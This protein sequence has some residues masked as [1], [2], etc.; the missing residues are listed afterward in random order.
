MAWSK[1]DSSWGTLSAGSLGFRNLAQ[2]ISGTRPNFASSVSTSMR[3]VCDARHDCPSSRFCSPFTKSASHVIRLA[4]GS[5]LY[6]LFEI[7]G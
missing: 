4:L 6:R 5:A 7:G 1:P 3:I 2:R